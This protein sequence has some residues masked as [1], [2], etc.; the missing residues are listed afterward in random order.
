MPTDIAVIQA[1]LSNPDVARFVS[2]ERVRFAHCDPAG[3]VFFPRYAELINGVVEDW[4]IDLGHP[5]HK[6]VTQL[7]TGC[8]TAQFDCRFIAPSYFG[9]TLKF[10]LMIEHLGRTSMILQHVITGEALDVRVLVQQRLVCTSLTT[11]RPQPWSEAV[12]H[13]IGLFRESQR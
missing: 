7:A 2:T 11:H 4:W 6:S 10:H 8:P 5:W 1:Q 13:S 9:E 12:L 3:I